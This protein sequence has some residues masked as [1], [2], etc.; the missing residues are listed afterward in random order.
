MTGE[1]PIQVN[2]L[3]SEGEMRLR[4]VLP[5][6]VSLSKVFLNILALLLSLG[7]WGAIAMVLSNWSVHYRC[8]LFYV[9]SDISC[10]SHF[11]V[12][13][14]NGDINII[15]KQKQDMRYFN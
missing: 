5:I 12:I 6:R 15:S 11:K 2:N 14:S 4:S 1:L 10:C 7:V 9:F 3:E 13:N 8:T